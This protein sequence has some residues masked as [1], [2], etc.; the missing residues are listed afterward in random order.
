MKVREKKNPLALGAANQFNTSALSEFIVGYY[1]GYFCPSCNAQLPKTSGQCSKCERICRDL[2]LEH[3]G[4]D[5]AFIRDF[6]VWIE[7][8]QKWK[9]MSQA[10][11]DSDLIVDN[12]NTIFF[13]PGNDEDRERGFT[14]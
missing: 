13:E 2:P 5:S 9:C 11:K 1:D 4:M 3:C 10:F 7:A 12:Y 6:E 14:L 8:L